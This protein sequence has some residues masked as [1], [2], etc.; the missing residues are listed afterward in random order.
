[1]TSLPPQAAKPIN[2]TGD[3]VPG[4]VTSTGS[5]SIAAAVVVGWSGPDPNSSTPWLAFVNFAFSG[6][7]QVTSVK[8]QYQ[9]S[10]PAI[11]LGSFSGQQWSRTMIFQTPLTNAQDGTL[12]SGGTVSIQARG[13]STTGESITTS[14]SVTPSSLR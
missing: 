7:L 4:S 10:N 6:P 1:M 9:D 11:A 5:I 13:M 12:F 3:I 2:G 14:C 8:I